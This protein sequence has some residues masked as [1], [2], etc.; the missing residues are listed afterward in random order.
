MSVE[1]EEEEKKRTLA[2][3]TA[4]HL[5]AGVATKALAVRNA[6]RK[7]TANFMVETIRRFWM[8]R[9]YDTPASAKDRWGD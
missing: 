6:T 3:R 2:S 5:A 8:C 1:N 9:T 7:A 4:S